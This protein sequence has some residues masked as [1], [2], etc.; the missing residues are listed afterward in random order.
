[1]KSISI[2]TNRK[3]M[4][5][6]NII[7]FL[8]NIM[9][10]FIIPMLLQEISIFSWIPKTLGGVI[11][12]LLLLLI[13][14]SKNKVNIFGCIG[15][16]I[17]SIIS[18]LNSNN[19]IINV[20]DLIY[21]NMFLLFC[22][23]IS[24]KEYI[25]QFSIAFKNNGKL[26]K[27]ILRLSNVIILL[28]YIFPNS[29]YNN[30][31]EGTKYFKGFTFMPHVIAGIAMYMLILTLYYYKINEKKYIS[32]KIYYIEKG[33]LIF[34]PII[35]ILSTGVRTYLIPLLLMIIYLTFIN[36][37]FLKNIYFKLGK[38]WSL[39]LILILSFITIIVFINT[40]IYAK[41]LYVINFA[42]SKSFISKI[43]S[44]RSDIW[45]ACI[46]SFI[47]DYN[48]QEKLFGTSFDNV[49]QIIKI[50][51]NMEI[52][53]HNDLVNTLMSSGIFGVA[54]YINIFSRVIVFIN[55][56]KINKFNIYI[57]MSI[58]IFIILVN[59]LFITVPVIFSML[60][61]IE[62]FMEEY[63]EKYIN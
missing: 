17:I 36:R 20:K 50:K 39:V 59:G 45:K 33:L 40:S 11:I 38:K 21:F 25:E 34:I 13:Y 42:Y 53:A 3:D 29:Y 58:Y 12:I 49:Y 62:I 61:F 46:D 47:Y 54:V 37:V 57:F 48:L 63:N 23:V 22:L 15:L 16:G 24:E 51:T 30:W 32:K 44:G 18:V 60:I 27:G 8:A 10:I 7:N 28:S 1:M 26:I 41:F 43:T 9:V 2:Y 31:G 56:L 5:Q 14:K 35:V 55:S 6:I 19:F 4:I 52:W